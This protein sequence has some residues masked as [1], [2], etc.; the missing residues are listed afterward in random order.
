[1]ISFLT[2]WTA[3]LGL[4]CQSSAY[5]IAE[6][7][8]REPCVLQVVPGP[9]IRVRSKEASFLCPTDAEFE[10]Q[11]ESIGVEP[12]SDFTLVAA[13]KVAGRYFGTTREPVPV[14]KYA[15]L[16]SEARVEYLLGSRR[17]GD[18][19]F[20]RDAQVRSV[21]LKLLNQTIV[22]DS[23]DDVLV[24]YGQ[25]YLGRAGSGRFRIDARRLV[26]GY[27]EFFTIPRLGESKFGTLTMS[28][29]WIPN[30]LQIDSPQD[31]I[32]VEGAVPR[33]S[34]RVK[35]LASIQVKEYKFFLDGR[36]I[37]VNE[38]AGG[39]FDFD[40]TYIPSG[41]HKVEIVSV[42]PDGISLAPE[43]T[44]I[45]IRNPFL[46]AQRVRNARITKVEDLTRRMVKLDQEVVSLYERAL[47]APE[48]RYVQTAR[49][50]TLSEWGRSASVT[51]IDS[52]Q[53]SG[54]AGRLM[55]ECKARILERA[56][57]AID[58]GLIFAQLG[59]NSE[60]RT[61]LQFALDSAGESNATGVLARS[62][63]AKVPK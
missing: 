35:N 4:G 6:G 8:S 50:L 14:A 61:W 56:R 25:E 21:S 22:A 46:D 38:Q 40:P 30:R 23:T 2:L 49:I 5:W 42:C 7:L 27:H 51:L 62:E 9:R 24:F 10:F 17:I 59:R 43:S 18:Y 31:Q 29:I 19:K 63:L 58:V 48:M 34:I 36:P 33:V 32:A 52:W 57:L 12:G 26:A 45:R 3:S 1:M 39:R 16:N 15:F 41:T 55:G 47:Q 13:G 53:V 20:K 11:P 44:T 54:D 28:Q 37:S 60:A